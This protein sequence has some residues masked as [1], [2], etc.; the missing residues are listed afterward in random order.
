MQKEQGTTPQQSQKER[1]ETLPLGHRGKRYCHRHWC[2]LREFSHR[3][4]PHIQLHLPTVTQT[5][6][7]MA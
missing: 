5:H 4:L 3:L 7:L 2:V 6:P 1:R